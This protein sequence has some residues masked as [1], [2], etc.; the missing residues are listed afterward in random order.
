VASGRLIIA[1]DPAS[2][3]TTETKS[4]IG[5]RNAIG[6]HHLVPKPRL[7]ANMESPPAREHI[8]ELGEIL[9]AGLIRLWGLKSSGKPQESREVSL[10]FLAVKSGHPTAEFGRIS[11]D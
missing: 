7:E 3:I 2:S 4:T 11:D 1:V 8:A 5:L 10:D 6:K 9:A